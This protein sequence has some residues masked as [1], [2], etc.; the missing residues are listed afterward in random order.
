MQIR[1]LDANINRHGHVRNVFVNGPVNDHASLS[2]GATFAFVFCEKPLDY[3]LSVYSAVNTPNIYRNFF[4]FFFQSIEQRFSLLNVN[5]TMFCVLIRIIS[6]KISETI[7]FEK[8]S[9]TRPM[10]Q[11]F[12]NYIIFSLMTWK[13]MGELL[14]NADKIQWKCLWNFLC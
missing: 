7:T 5:L 1:P 4:F 13:N 3:R 10:L 2:R 14:K 12:W 6:R 11:Y 9:S 8:L